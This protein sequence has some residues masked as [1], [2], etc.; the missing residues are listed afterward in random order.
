M[1]EKTKYILSIVLRA[2]NEVLRYIVN[3]KKDTDK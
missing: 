2:I 1:K 3:A